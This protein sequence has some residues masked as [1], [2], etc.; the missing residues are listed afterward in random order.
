[1]SDPAK[2]IQGPNLNAVQ[3]RLRADWVKLWLYNPKWITPYTSMPLNYP[4][5]N[6]SQFPDLFKGEPDAH[7]IGTRDALMNYNRLM[8]DLG[9][10]NYA[11]PTATPAAAGAAEE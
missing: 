7:V 6:T 11:P 10:T 2:D 5:N 1:V 8:E 9:P 3:N 4:K